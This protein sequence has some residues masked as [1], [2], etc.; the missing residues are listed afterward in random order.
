V[1]VANDR[2]QFAENGGKSQAVV[3]MACI[4][5]DDK[6]KVVFS[7]GKTLTLTGNATSANAPDAAPIG[8][9][10]K[11]AITFAFPVSAPGLYQ[12][13]VAAR[14]SRSGLVGSVF[15]WVEVPDLKARRMALSS[16]FLIETRRAR[17]A[18]PDASE[19]NATAENVLKADRRFARSSRLLLQFHIYNAARQTNGSGAPDVEVEIKIIDSN[20]KALMST[21]PSKVSLAGATDLSRIPYAADVALGRLPAGVYQLQV[22]VTDRVGRTTATRQ[23]DFAVE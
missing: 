2:L 9:R 20:N 16:L 6:G 14:D 5:L 8:G 10:G 21:P 22:A 13:R 12:F 7:E 1:Q 3:E 18:S 15:R 11:V 19:T 17:Q 23:L 4:V